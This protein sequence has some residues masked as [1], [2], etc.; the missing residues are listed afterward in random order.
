M[1]IAIIPNRI[2][3]TTCV[4]ENLHGPRRRLKIRIDANV[5]KWRIASDG[6]AYDCP[7]VGFIGVVFDSVRRRGV[8]PFE[9]I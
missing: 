4:R 8:V 7:I 2:S 6:S 1:G 9:V 3:Q 5:E